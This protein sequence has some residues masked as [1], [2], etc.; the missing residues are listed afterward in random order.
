MSR[1]SSMTKE[2]EASAERQY[3]ERVALLKKHVFHLIV[4]ECTKK[5]LFFRSGNGCWCCFS[6]EDK[7]VAEFSKKLT[8]LLDTCYESDPYNNVG[9]LVGDYGDPK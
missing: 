7:S 3:D 6:R 5:N 8:E 4:A 2:L 1:W 9:S